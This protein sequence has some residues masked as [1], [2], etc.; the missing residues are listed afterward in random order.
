[1]VICLCQ[2]IIIVIDWTFIRTQYDCDNFVALS[3]TMEQRYLGLSG[4]WSYSVMKIDP[5]VYVRITKKIL[6]Q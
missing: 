2:I 1:M 4:S 3:V 6:A 5:N